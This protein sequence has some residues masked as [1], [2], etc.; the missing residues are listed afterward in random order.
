MIVS[1]P[2]HIVKI[3]LPKSPYDIRVYE[4]L[5]DVAEVWDQLDGGVF[6][7]STYLMNAEKAHAD[8][9]RFV[10]LLFYKEAQLIGKAYCQIIHFD[11][12]QSLK[13]ERTSG[14]PTIFSELSRIMKYFL[15]KNISMNILVCGSLLLSGERGF[16]FG[17]ME[18]Q[19]G[20]N[21]LNESLEGLIDHY[22]QQDTIIPIVLLK[23]VDRKLEFAPPVNAISEFHHFCIHP[24][25]ELNIRTDW[26]HFENYLGSLNSKYRV[27]AKK[28][29]KCSSQLK[30]RSLTYEDTL[31]Y[32]N[33][34]ERLFRQIVNNAS[35]N[36]VN[37]DFEYF[38]GLKKTL[39]DKFNV[40]GYFDRAKLVAFS[41]TI[42]DR[43]KLTAHYLGYDV[44]L[45]K[46]YKLYMRILYDMVG[47]AIG[48]GVKL[49]NFARTALEI[50]STIGAEPK[51]YSCYIRHQ[52]SLNNKIVPHIVDYFN[53]VN[54]WI[55]RKPFKVTT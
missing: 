26:G 33:Q 36:M 17:N 18:T 38:I 2:M 31:K 30:M 10:Y 41:T 6:L 22:H 49:I 42:T 45:N 11:L 25:M 9:I 23:D 35:F 39:G 37:I 40:T 8:G 50:K 44:E 27:R 16:Y 54:D 51:Q 4:E 1:K 53:P 19:A 21:L 52:R 12:D 5:R 34:M 46:N 15:A 32:R 47:E 7:E 28:A 14:C 29:I 43:D 3:A 13:I 48:K 55:Q 24:L 20:L